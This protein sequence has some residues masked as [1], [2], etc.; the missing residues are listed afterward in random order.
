MFLSR[1]SRPEEKRKETPKAA[2]RIGWY[3]LTREEVEELKKLK[4][5]SAKEK[6]KEKEK[7]EK[8]K[9]V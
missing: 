1:L 6:E 5:E 2:E 3:G 4:E 9:K 8:D 7:T